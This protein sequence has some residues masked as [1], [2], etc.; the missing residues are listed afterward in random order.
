LATTKGHVTWVVGGLVLLGAAVGTLYADRRER[1][2]YGADVAIVCHAEASSN[3]TLDRDRYGVEEWA[4]THL[5][6]ARARTLLARLRREA[7][8]VAAGELRDESTGV[9]ACPAVEGYESLGRR[10]RK[11]QAF[12]RMCREV[13]P[14]AL[15]RAPRGARVGRLLAWSGEHLGD[16]GAAIDPVLGPLRGAPP[17]KAAA[18]L[19]GRLADLDIHI[20]GML[21]GLAAKTDPKPGPNVLLEMARVDDA[22]EHEVTSALQARLPAIQNCYAAEL[23]RSP[24]LAGTLNVKLHLTSRGTIDLALPQPDSTLQ[25]A[26][27]AGC[28]VAEMRRIAVDAGATSSTGGADFELFVVK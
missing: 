21:P 9:G 11:Q 13:D 8:D 18:E 6:T 22:R 10:M 26:V 5:R 25:S 12:D 28:A 16:A 1:R 4:Q 14:R 19:R 7:A 20:C 23:A 2:H 3:A 27:V 17:E 24:G 15:E